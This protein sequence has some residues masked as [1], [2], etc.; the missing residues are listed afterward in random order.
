MAA[1]G[2]AGLPR[3]SYERSL[4]AL[5]T[6]LDSWSGIGHVAVAMHRQGFDLQLTQYA[7]RGWR[8]ASTR[9]AWSIRPRARRAPLGAHAVAR[10]AAGGVGSLA[11]GWKREVGYAREISLL[12]VG[13]ATALLGE[14][15]RTAVPF[16]PPPAFLTFAPAPFV[17]FFVP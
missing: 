7:E 6:W 3:P 11:E 17:V 13:S 9:P 4:W 2:F 8:A 5:R 10:D 12:T 1:L 15:R 16:A 14:S